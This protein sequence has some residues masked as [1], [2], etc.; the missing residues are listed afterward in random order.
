MQ[1]EDIT[2]QISEYRNE[3]EARPAPQTETG[4]IKGWEEQLRADR[5]ALSPV[6]PTLPTAPPVAKEHTGVMSSTP[7]TGGSPLGTPALVSPHGN[8]RVLWAQP[9]GVW[10]G[11]TKGGGASRQ[12]QWGLGG[13][14]AHRK[15]NQRPA[16]LQPS[17]LAQ[18][19]QGTRVHPSLPNSG[20]QMKSSRS[21]AA[22]AAQIQQRSWVL[23]PLPILHGDHGSQSLLPESLFRKSGELSKVGSPSSTQAE[24]GS[25]PCPPWS[26]VPACPHLTGRADKNTQIPGSCTTQQFLSWW[27]GERAERVV[28]RAKLVAPVQ[29]VNLGRRLTW[30]KTTKSTSGLGDT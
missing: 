11:Q 23:A 14:S 28:P 21:P 1:E 8:H 20:L 22:W 27:A 25:Q 2:E 6:W 18:S 13:Q 4:C 17:W 15:P 24:V 9:L 10:L 30:V 19:G 5:R 26:V 16:L 3:A 29:P 12:Q 7:S